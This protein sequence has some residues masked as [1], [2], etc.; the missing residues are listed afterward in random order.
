MR[1]W[2]W[3]P[4][5]IFFGGVGYSITHTVPKSAIARIFNT[6]LCEYRRSAYSMMDI[7]SWHLLFVIVNSIFWGGWGEK[8][9]IWYCD[10]PGLSVIYDSYCLRLELKKKNDHLMISLSASDVTLTYLW[11]PLESQSQLQWDL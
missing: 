4:Q 1:Y 5:Y 10:C 6:Y 11:S 7:L 9:N 8:T 2:G 3:R